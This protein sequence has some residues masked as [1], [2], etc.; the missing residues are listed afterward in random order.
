MF[1]MKRPPNNTMNK[2][3]KVLRSKSNAS[4]RSVEHHRIPYPQHNMGYLYTEKL[5]KSSIAW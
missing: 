2:Q 3:R 1:I 5:G 4:Y